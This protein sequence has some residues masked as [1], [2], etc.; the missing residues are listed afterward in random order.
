LIFTFFGLRW[1][2]SLGLVWFRRIGDVP[3]ITRKSKSDWY[4]IGREL[5]VDREQGVLAKLLV[6]LCA[7]IFAVASVF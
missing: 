2:Q 4:I 7:R 6:E 3:Q 5:G 1:A